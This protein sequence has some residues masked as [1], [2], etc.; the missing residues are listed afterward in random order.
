MKGKLVLI[1]HLG[2]L[3]ALDTLIVVSALELGLER[4]GYRFTRG[5]GVA[6]VQ[7]VI[8]QTAN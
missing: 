4:L 2:Y 3:G 8:A 1:G 5:A 6:A 7:G